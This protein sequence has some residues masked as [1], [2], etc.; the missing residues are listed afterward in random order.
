MMNWIIRV[1]SVA[2]LL[3]A[4]GLPSLVPSVAGLGYNLYLDP[5]FEFRESEN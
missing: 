2:G 4:H 3:V 5:G 1:V